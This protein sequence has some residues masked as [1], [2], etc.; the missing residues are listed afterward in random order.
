MFYLTFNKF[1]FYDI[2]RVI[3]NRYRPQCKGRSVRGKA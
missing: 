1:I 2:K 3:D